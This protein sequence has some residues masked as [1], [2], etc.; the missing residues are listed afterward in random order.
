MCMQLASERNLLIIFRPGWYV[1][2][3]SWPQLLVD[4]TTVALLEIQNVQAQLLLPGSQS[5]L[6]FRQRCQR[7]TLSQPIIVFCFNRL[8]L[9][10]FNC[11]YGTGLFLCRPN[12][13]PVT[14]T[15]PGRVSL[16]PRLCCACMHDDVMSRACNHARV[17]ADAV[18][19]H[20]F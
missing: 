19:S 2:L 6:R 11:N 8:L 10:H 18:Q 12:L 16:L 9:T 17:A 3:N 5:T 13:G 20:G 15:S 7:I 14:R 1:A 4:R